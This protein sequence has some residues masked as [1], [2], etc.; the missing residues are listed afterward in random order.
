[1]DPILLR[2]VKDSQAGQLPH[3]LGY[4]VG[5]P[6]SVYLISPTRFLKRSMV[7]Q[8]MTLPILYNSVRAA[9]AAARAMSSQS[10]VGV[11]YSSLSV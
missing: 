9:S 5:F 11:E 1:M 2:W 4:A 3:K 7:A 6:W 10:C 8:Q